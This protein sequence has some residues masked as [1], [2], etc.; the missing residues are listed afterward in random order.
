MHFLKCS[1]CGH[2]NEVKSEYLIFCSRCDKKLD[3]NYSDWKR[4]NSDK[5]FDDFKQLICNT[6]A[7]ENLK[8][9]SKT[10]PGMPKGLKYGI[11]ITIGVA[12]IVAGFYAVVHFAGDTIVGFLKKPIYD[13]IMVSYANQINKNCPIMIDVNTRFDNATVLPGNVFQ[14][15]YTLVNMDKANI[16]IDDLKNYMEPKV[17]NWVKTSPEMKALRDIKITFNYYYKDK[18][19]VYLLTISVT[20]DKYQ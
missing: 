15:N 16:N 2:F 13:K 4:R 1:K 14:Y 3:N 9:K 6:E 19:G 7:Q 18:A 10:K 17:T 5:S 12:F 11:V 8:N 20:P